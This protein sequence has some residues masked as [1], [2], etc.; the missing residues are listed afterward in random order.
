M[1]GEDAAGAAGGE[2]QG[3][4]QGGAGAPPSPWSGLAA[5]DSGWVQAKGFKSLPD[6]VKAYRDL[7]SFKGAPAARLLTLPEKEDAPE[8]S[9]VFAKIGRPEKPEGYE[10]TGADPELLAALHKEGLTKRQAKNLAA[11]LTS[12]AQ[13]A[14]LAQTEASQQELQLE[15]AAL[16][17]EWGGEYD[18]NVKHGQQLLQRIYEK[19]GFTSKEEA[20]GFL[21]AMQKAAGKGGY[22]K[23][24]K[25]FAVL[26]RG[27]VPAPFADGNSSDTGDGF[28]MTPQA[29]MSAFRALGNDSAFMAKLDA[30]DVAAREKYERLAKL[31]APLFSAG[32]PQH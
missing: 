3:A 23:V 17:R 6:F 5:D 13:S 4:G 24:M 12:R 11:V 2:G 22:S 32:G 30:G 15:D 1:A 14:T 25:F 20:D 7:E 27:T 21:D 9:D 29:A 28:G 26:G 31:A 18:A 10:I 8:W 16:R 19:V